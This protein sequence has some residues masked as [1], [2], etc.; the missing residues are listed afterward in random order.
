MDLLKTMVY[1]K[2]P[3]ACHVIRDVVMGVKTLHEEKL[4]HRDIKPENI[5]ISDGVLKLADFGWSVRSTAKNRRKTYC[6]TLD[7]TPPEMLVSK[8]TGRQNS[9]DEYVDIWTVGVFTYEMNVGKA[10]FE[11]RSA[12]DTEKRIW[13]NKFDVPQHFSPELKDFIVRVLQTDPSKRLTLAQMLEHPWITG[14]K[15][16]K[17]SLF[18]S[19]TPIMQF[20]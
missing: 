11:A 14:K 3:I 12:N 6:G 15:L 13:H 5:L 1:L 18:R 9:Y 19:I 4:I 2:E 10:P 7:Y 20:K 8:M 16:E 17:S